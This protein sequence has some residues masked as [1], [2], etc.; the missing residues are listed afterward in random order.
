MTYKELQDRV[1]GRLNL[2]STEART[3]I[4]IF[5]NERYRKLATSIGL[6]RV[7]WGTV[8]F[9]TIIGTFTYSPAT[10]IKPQTLFYPA[11]NKVLQQM[12]M[13][14]IRI[15]DP[16]SSQTGPP[17]GW[18]LQK[19]NANTCTMY[20]WPK[21]DAIYAL[22]ADGMVTGTDMAADGDIP[23]IPE[24]FHDILEFAATADELAK[25]EKEKLSGVME[26]KA[27]ARTRDLRYFMAKST[28]LSL[29][30]GSGPQWWWGP[31]WSTYQGFD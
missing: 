13:D 30:Q 11:G 12:T 28:Y 23:V 14:Q 6:M 20:I 15:L 1:M 17:I 4:K 9:N 26:M 24:D 27:E 19:F 16:D 2:T 5:L 18:V 29:Q 3:R 22:S 7:R 8:S 21:P 25:M 31:W 10:L